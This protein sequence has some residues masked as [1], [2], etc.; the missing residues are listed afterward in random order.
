MGYG[1]L[2]GTAAAAA[3]RPEDISA[4]GDARSQTQQQQMQQPAESGGRRRHE[5]PA[6]RTLVEGEVSMMMPA[7]ATATAAPSTRGI[8]PTNTKRKKH[9]LMIIAH[10]DDEFIF[11]GEQL[12][13]SDRRN[14]TLCPL[15][16]E[17]CQW[18]IVVVSNGTLGANAYDGR[19][20]REFEWAVQHYSEVYSTVTAASCLHLNQ[21]SLV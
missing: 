16:A 2:K 8:A 4:P 21:V 1:H 3:A 7:T 10:P 17:D 5:N 6:E 20:M 9:V 15:G 13:A 14:R 11:G 12:L 19:R 18:E